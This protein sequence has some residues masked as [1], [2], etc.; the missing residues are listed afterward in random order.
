MSLRCN[1][2]T[3]NRLDS[4]LSLGFIALATCCISNIALAS[5]WSAGVD[6]RS[7]LPTLSKGGNVALSSAFVF[8]RANWVFA[9]EQ[10]EFE[11]R[12]PFIYSIAGKNQALNFDLAGRITRASDRQLVWEFDLDVHSASSHVVGGGMSF[13]FD[14]SSFG[15]EL[16]E[17]ELLPGNLG[18]TWGRTNGSRIEMRFD[19][20]LAAVY[21]ER[22][23][24]S[25]VRAFFYKDEI[26]QGLRHYVATVSI[27]GDISLGPTA[28]EKFGLDD[29][30]A[31]PADI[32]GL[33]ISPV[34]LSFLNA[35]EKPAGRRGFLE[36]RGD[37][38]VFDDHTLA[39]FWGTNLTAYSLFG[40]P[41]A[42]VKRQ[43]HRIS[44]LGFNLV[45]LHHHDSE[46]VKPNIFG[47]QN[48][49]NTQTLNAD[50]LEKLDWW[51]KCLKD[52]GIYVWLDLHVG[53]RVRS[54]DA[55]QDFDEIR[56]GKSSATL[57]GYNY[58]NDSIR[59]AMKRFDDM[60]LNHQNRFTGLRYR[61]DPA[62]VTLLITNENDLTHH[63]GNAL[64]PD[65]GV[66]RHSVIYMREAERF[67]AKYALPKDK[68]WRAWEDG[69][70]KL[71]LNDLE[72][73]FDI[74]MIAHLRA[75]GVK[76][77][78]VTTSTW[79]MNPLSSLPVLTVGNII[80]VHS[81]GGVGELERNPIFGANLVHWIAAA[82]VVGKPLTVTEWGVDS[83]GSLA[84][85][86]QDM[87][88]Y[89]A[90]SA[91]MQGWD[92]VMFFAYSHEPLTDRSTPSIY[93]AHNDPALMA[94]LPAAALLYR[95]GHVKE[96]TT[97]YVF[98]PSKE[99]LFDQPIAAAN[100][101]ALRTAS[102]R[103]RLMIAMPRVPELPWLEK[104]AVP[105]GSKIINDPQQ[106]QI[107]V[108]ASEVVSDSG[109]LKRNWDQGTFTISTPRTQAAMG[110]I[111]GK[112]ITLPEVEVAVTTR[113][114][115]VAVQ[116][117]DGN[118]IGQ[119]RKIMISLGARSVPRAEN[120][121]PYYSE[122]V[123]GRILV[124]APPGL[125]LRVSDARSGKLR[126]VPASYKDGRYI[127]ALDRSLR[128]SW[129]VMDGHR[130]GP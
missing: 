80:D 97:R 62:I 130:G 122:P 30:T 34:D 128:S 48:T 50:M 110:W 73:R 125:N 43:A 95:Q 2:S 22:G 3:A 41:K 74:D 99:M 24:K 40:T 37:K 87:P 79:G 70:S 127:L 53:R 71:F 23:Q 118:P 81:Y 54:G 46:W 101:V 4:L 114:S 57:S 107:P 49:P 103:G 98:E 113:N 115:V 109:E 56:Q 129:L 31:W 83:H 61:D 25:E 13:T 36:A 88:L 67:A 35:P 102:E 105:P 100:S 91:S 39:R 108:N 6:E 119:S 27:S 52:E 11:V 12:A 121:L 84:P 32:M 69:P 21:F 45:R 104:S 16:G 5:P 124:S 55:I 93:Q 90:G 15:S 82:Q 44:E 58:V 59:D 1:I 94:S 19:H 92:A 65:K 14:L 33:D 63:F 29:H 78:I 42:D 75:L 7:G 116:S 10:T 66:P 17:P 111:G 38:L 117:L 126:R 64:L 26:P 86:R 106:S 47:D 60:Y 77:P 112:T 8:W 9:D 28:L 123:E 85:D 20:P 68:V 18:W 51:I 76:V 72:Q 120:S 89:I 96:A